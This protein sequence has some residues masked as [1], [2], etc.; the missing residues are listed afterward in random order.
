MSRVIFPLIFC[1]IMFSGILNSQTN[2]GRFSLKAGVGTDINLG[3][4]YG[5]GIGYIF[6]YSDVELNVVLFGHHSEETTEDFHSYT[7]TTDLFVYGV[8][9]NYLI[10]FPGRESGAYGVV[11]FGFAAVSLD[12]E[13]TSPTDVSL[14]PPLPGGGS[15]QSE[16][17]TGGGSV[18][19][20]GFGYSFGSNLHLRAEFPVIVAFSP[21]GEAAGVAPTFMFTL[22]YYF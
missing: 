13:E 21:P 3:L 17:G 14:G 22:G 1:F 5:G 12:W 6:P 19:N 15:K 18:F 20:A 7:E 9:A 16:S 11:G 8:M 4:G 10:G 2:S